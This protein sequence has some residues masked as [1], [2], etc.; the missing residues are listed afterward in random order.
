MDAQLNLEYGYRCFHGY[1]LRFL[2]VYTYL[3]VEVGC[4]I[5]QRRGI[6]DKKGS[7]EEGEKK[8]VVMWV[9]EGPWELG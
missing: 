1:R 8:Y 7:K 5:F 3:G 2:R 9:V 6:W 4:G